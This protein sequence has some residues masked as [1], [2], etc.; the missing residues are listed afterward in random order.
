MKISDTKLR[1]VSDAMDKLMQWALST[2]TRLT[3][4]SKTLLK[5]LRSCRSDDPNRRPFRSS[6]THDHHQY[7]SDDSD[8]EDEEEENEDPYSEF[9]SEIDQ[10]DD[11]DEEYSLFLTRVAENVMQLSIAFITQ[12]FPSGDDLHSPLV[13]FADIMGICNRLSRFNEAYNYTTHVASLMWMV[14]LLTLEYALG[15]FISVR[16]HFHI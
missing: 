5:W 13:H 8:D 2:L 12:Y 3:R 7:D 15:Q 11:D 14:R 1:T 10:V 9:N 6:G 4:R 16:T